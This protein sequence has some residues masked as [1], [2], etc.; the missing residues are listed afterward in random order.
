VTSVIP[1]R[2]KQIDLYQGRTLDV[3]WILYDDDD[4]TTPT[5][6]TGWKAWL[7]IWGAD[8]ATPVKVLSYATGVAPTPTVQGT[9]GVIITALTGAI[10]AYLTDE[11]ALALSHTQFTEAFD[12]NGRPFYTG[13]YELVLEDPAAE[14]F[15]YEIGPVRFIRSAPIS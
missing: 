13:G 4:E 3:P 5:V 12:D 11:D 1:A 9:S 15:P 8:I 6:L 2:G 10:R 14:R 7:L